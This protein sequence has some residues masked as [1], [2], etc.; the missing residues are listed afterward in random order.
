MGEYN[1]GLQSFIGE[2]GHVA[3]DQSYCVGSSRHPAV[4]R[5]WSGVRGEA[6]D[7]GSTEIDKKM[8]F[9]ALLRKEVT[10]QSSDEK[11]PPLA[12]RLL[13]W[14]IGSLNRDPPVNSECWTSQP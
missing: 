8:C 4:K 10:V 2:F 5:Q 1:R 6:A 13:H 3:E 7:A 9:A 11:R 12:S 14:P